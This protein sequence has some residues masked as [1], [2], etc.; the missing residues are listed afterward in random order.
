MAVDPDELVNL[1][2]DPA[3]LATRAELLG[4]LADVSMSLEDRSA[5]RLQPW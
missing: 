5:P 2:D 1:W 3:H 4:R